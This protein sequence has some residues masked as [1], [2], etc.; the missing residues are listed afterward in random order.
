MKTKV[1]KNRDQAPSADIAALVAQK[2]K[3]Q[4]LFADKI[5]TVKKFLNKV[6]ISAL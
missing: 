6:K 3:G 2:L 4:T 1:I 5:E